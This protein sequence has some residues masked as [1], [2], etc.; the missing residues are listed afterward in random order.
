[1]KK[2]KWIMLTVGVGILGA[3]AGAGAQGLIEQVKG[4]LRNDVG[5]SVNGEA[6]SLHPVYIK[7]KAYLPARETTTAMGYTMHW[8]GKG[9][10]IDIQGTKGGGGSEEEKLIPVSGVIVSAEPA[11]NQVRVEV[12]GHGPNKWIILFVDKETALTNAEGKPFAA[13]DLKAGMRITAEYGPAIALSYPG[14][15]HA[16]KLQV[17]GESLVKEQAISDV[18]KTDDGWQV[19][20]SENGKD[21]SLVLTAG[22]ETMVVNA[23]GE[24]VDWNALK[25]GSN[26]RAYY[27]PMTTKSLPPQS[28]LHVLVVLDEQ[29][30]APV[31]VKEYRNLAWSFLPKEQKSHV[32]TKH[33]D[34]EVNFVSAADVS[35]MT[36][37]DR[38]KQL[39]ADLKAKGGKLATVTYNTDQDELLGPI[40]VAI[41][42]ETKELVGF[43]ARR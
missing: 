11:G 32:T 30:Q 20:F 39:L 5:I 24:S 43:F 2:Q 28:P 18:K 19:S 42:V 34:A 37:T 41:D 6:T 9:K 38:Q 35:V 36:T 15:S 3:S 8:D 22:K 31:D 26:V 12:L 14:Q 10:R 27:G 33:Q 17:Q 1:M 21:T 7:G 16:V 4:V 29:T 25:K 13:A 23:Q 40:T